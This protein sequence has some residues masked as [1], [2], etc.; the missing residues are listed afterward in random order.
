[1]AFLHNKCT[2]CDRSRWVHSEKTTRQHSS[3]NNR[4]GQPH[5]NSVYSKLQSSRTALSR[6][7]ADVAAP[8]TSLR[9]LPAFSD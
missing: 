6:G 2:A 5:L 4:L 7:T 8:T 9:A 1:M 3:Y